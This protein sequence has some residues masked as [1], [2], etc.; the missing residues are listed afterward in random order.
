MKR[1]SPSSC[2]FSSKR[3]GRADHDRWPHIPA[4]ACGIERRRSRH[5]PAV[6]DGRDLHRFSAVLFDR[7]AIEPV[8]LIPTPIGG[9]HRLLAVRRPSHLPH[10]TTGQS[11]TPARFTAA[12]GDRPRLIAS[13]DIAR[14]RHQGGDGAKVAGSGD[15]GTKSRYSG[16]GASFCC[17]ESYQLQPRRTVAAPTACSLLQGRRLLGLPCS[18]GA[19]QGFRRYLSSPRK[20]SAT[21]SGRPWR[22]PRRGLEHVRTVQ[23]QH[24][25]GSGH[26]AGLESPRRERGNRSPVEAD[27][28]HIPGSSLESVLPLDTTSWPSSLG[29]VVGSRRTTGAGR[30]HGLGPGSSVT[31]SERASPVLEPTTSCAPSRSSRSPRTPRRSR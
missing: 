8:P 9:E 5:S 31:P 28:H 29:D 10:R 15:G 7:D 19:L 4:S 25:H 12:D 24:R 11:C 16:M 18:V 13:G 23:R 14:I 3:L 21:G 26:G 6:T 2:K 20:A 30:P 17:E 1:R 22:M 27:A